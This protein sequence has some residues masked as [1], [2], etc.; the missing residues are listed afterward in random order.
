MAPLDERTLLLW[1][2]IILLVITVTV[3]GMLLNR[4]FTHRAHRRALAELRRRHFAPASSEVLS[5]LKAS[6]AERRANADVAS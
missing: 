2:G 4:F 6:F 1:L 3:S 5:P